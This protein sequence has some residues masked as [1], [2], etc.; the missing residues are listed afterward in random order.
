MNFSNQIDLINEIMPIRFQPDEF[1]LDKSNQ[2]KNM[3]KHIDEID[4][5][6]LLEIYFDIHLNYRIKFKNEKNEALFY[7][8][9]FIKK[10]LDDRGE[11]RDE[12]VLKRQS[13]IFKMNMLLITLCIVY[14]VAFYKVLFVN[15]I[16]FIITTISLIFWATIKKN[17]TKRNISKTNMEYVKMV[18]KY[19]LVCSSLAVVYNFRNNNNLYY[20]SGSYIVLLILHIYYIS[21]MHRYSKK[22][23]TAFLKKVSN[24]YMY[25]LLVYLIVCSF[26]AFL[27]SSDNL[28]HTPAFVEGVCTS[29]EQYNKDKNYYIVTINNT[30]MLINKNKVHNKK[31]EDSFEIGNYYVIRYGEITKAIVSVEK[32][33]M[34]K[35][36]G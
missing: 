31:N 12:Y 17:L 20:I 9:E 30:E 13:N 19:L 2:D 16:I 8:Y 33:D 18:L 34:L 11:K 22:I 3:K 5:P 35:R 14:Y 28:F 36:N 27:D 23:K 21:T 29:I 24:I 32:R 15:K 4:T 25:S 10:T 1:R 26:P 7:L 6:K